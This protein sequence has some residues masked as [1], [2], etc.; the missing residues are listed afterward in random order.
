[1]SYKIPCSDLGFFFTPGSLFAASRK[2]CKAY[3]PPCSMGRATSYPCIPGCSFL[4]VCF[5]LLCPACLCSRVPASATVSTRL[6]KTVSSREAKY[7][8]NDFSVVFWGCKGLFLP[9]VCSFP[10]SRVLVPAISGKVTPQTC[11]SWCGG[12]QGLGG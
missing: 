7:I 2:D 10:C 1:M 9:P 8:T 11:Q 6:V 5:Q 12:R 3:Y 4:L